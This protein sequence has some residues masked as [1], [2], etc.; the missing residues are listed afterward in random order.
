MT[1][2][3]T[4]TSRC[5]ENSSEKKAH[6]SS[7]AEATRCDDNGNDGN[8]DHLSPSDDCDNVEKQHVEN[9]S[10]KKAHISGGADMTCCDDN[11]NDSND[12]HLSPS[13][14]CDHV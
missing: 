6:I 12:D 5:V 1:I 13:D 7:G 10:K 4:T 8:D 3:T 11:G 2:G 9:S 14:G